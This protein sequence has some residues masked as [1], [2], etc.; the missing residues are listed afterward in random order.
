MQKHQYSITINA[1]REKIWDVL[2]GKTT[3]PEWTKP[4][5]E[6]SKVETTWEEGSKAL[7]LGNDNMGMVSRIARNNKPAFLSI[8]HLGMVKDGVEDTTSEKVKQWAGSF[9][10]YTLTEEN[11]QTTLLIDIDIPGDYKDYFDKTWPLALQKVKEI[12]EQA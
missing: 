1:S 12:S 7:F 8:E 4:F 11:G 10:N 5:N 3:Y 2:L 9:E 6:G